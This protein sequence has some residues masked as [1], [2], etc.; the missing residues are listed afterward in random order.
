[1]Q[2]CTQGI[3]A[4]TSQNHALC[5]I[6]R[7]NAREC[8]RLAASNSLYFVDATAA[9]TDT[10]RRS[11]AARKCQHMPFTTTMRTSRVSHLWTVCHRV[12]LWHAI[13]QYTPLGWRRCLQTNADRL[14]VCKEAACKDQMAT[15]RN[16]ASLAEQTWQTGTRHRVRGSRPGSQTWCVTMRQLRGQAH[17]SAPHHQR[18]EPDHEND[19]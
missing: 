11:L 9:N 13:A 4:S 7:E 2:S 1:V 14:A 18:V 12:A 8:L 16:V 17:Q 6:M 3:D 5:Q 19:W 10:L 15:L